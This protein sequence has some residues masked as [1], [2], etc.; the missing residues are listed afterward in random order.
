MRLD[1]VHLLDLTLGP[2]PGLW[3]SEGEA[4]EESSRRGSQDPMF[5]DEDMEAGAREP[6]PQ[7]AALGFLDASAQPHTP[8]KSIPAP[9][10]L[11]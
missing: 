10:P 6:Q 3:R 7:E 4:K 2:L 5:E 9:P 1:C 8:H 11:F